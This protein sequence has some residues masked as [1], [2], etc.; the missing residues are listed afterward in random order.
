M[1]LL[2]LLVVIVY[3]NSSSVVMFHWSLKEIL[4]DEVLHVCHC[5]TQKHRP[6]RWL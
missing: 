3:H 2:S 1:I 6:V 5:G 4:G